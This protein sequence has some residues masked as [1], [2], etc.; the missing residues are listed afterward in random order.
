MRT[1]RVAVLYTHPLFGRGIAQLLSR[2]GRL[3][4]ACLEAGVAEAPALADTLAPD[5]I[6]I[7][8][9]DDAGQLSQIIQAL[10]PVLVAVVHLQD[11]VM[12]V[13]QDRRRIS[14]TPES[15]VEAITG[16]AVSY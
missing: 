4:V 12:D 15:L 7:E 13:Y 11:N 5:A 16:L 8:G 3:D 14:P 2:D 9:C 6:V 1:Q 10:P